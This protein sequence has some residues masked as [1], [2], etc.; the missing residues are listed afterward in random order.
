MWLTGP[1]PILIHKTIKIYLCAQTDNI[2]K[3]I[4]RPFHVVCHTSQQRSLHTL[5]PSGGSAQSRSERIHCQEK[6]KKRKKGNKYE[7]QC[8]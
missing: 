3:D 1:L 7:D 6:E 2:H 5:H 8:F 4:S